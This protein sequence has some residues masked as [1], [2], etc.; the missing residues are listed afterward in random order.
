MGRASQILSPNDIQAL[1]AEFRVTLKA[2]NRAPNTISLYLRSLDK[3]RAFL[4][5]RG[6]PST[7]DAI[8]REH[9]E[10]FLADMLERGYAPASAK[11]YYDGIRQFWKWLV[12]EGE[13]AEVSNPMRNVKAP[14][15]ILQMAPVLT[16]AQIRSLLKACEGRSFDEVRDRALIM[17]MFDTGIR[18]AECAG[19]ALE[20][21]DVT[22]RQEVRVLGKGRKIREV[23]FGANTARAL[24]RY[25]RIR[26][27]HPFSKSSAVWL[28]VRGPMTG[29]GIRQV[30]E[31]RSAEAG[32]GHVSPHTLRH[33]FAHAWL[34]AGG[35]ETDLMRLAGWSSRQMLQRYAAAR[36]SER[37]KSAHR[38]L[39]P[40]DR[41]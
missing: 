20:D 17:L 9:L 8:A 3:L 5:E 37:A 12:E 26:R 35:E 14:R 10:A 31:R 30:L 2:T 24:G 21:V 13:V 41:L 6:M 1:E 29:S 33:S 7:V 34:E 15:V 32:I 19:L 39:S 25:L 11:A 40:G 18:L 36:A 22:D 4:A 16:I 23:P 27:S 28:G 38:R